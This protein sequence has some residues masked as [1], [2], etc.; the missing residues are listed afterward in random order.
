[1][2]RYAGQQYAIPVALLQHLMQIAGADEPSI[3]ESTEPW[4]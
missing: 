3:D 1:V 2:A 4:Q